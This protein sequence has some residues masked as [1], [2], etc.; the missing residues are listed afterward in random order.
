MLVHTLWGAMKHSAD[1][2]M[3]HWYISLCSENR[4]SVVTRSLLQTAQNQILAFDFTAVVTVQPCRCKTMHGDGRCHIC[5]PV[6]QSQ[7]STDRVS[8]SKQAM[9]L[10]LWGHEC[11]TTPAELNSGLSW[12]AE[13]AATAAI[14]LVTLLASPCN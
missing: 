11:C 4:S 1:E 2:T 14:I 3:L 9:A 5:A 10:L 13:A 6:L 7:L 8:H 12:K